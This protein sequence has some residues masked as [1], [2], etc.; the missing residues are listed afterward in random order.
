[1][2]RKPIGRRKIVRKKRVRESKA[3]TTDR[4]RKNAGKV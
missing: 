4:D 3:K 1:L 2:E